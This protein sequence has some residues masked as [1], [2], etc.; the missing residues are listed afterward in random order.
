VAQ[1]GQ[2]PLCQEDEFSS[3]VAEGERRPSGET[4]RGEFNGVWPDVDM[5]CTL[6]ENG[7]NA[8]TTRKLRRPGGDELMVVP[9]QGRDVAPFRPPGTRPAGSAG[10]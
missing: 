9:R 8:V 10:F 2:D 5:F 6:L 4:A 3:Y 7:I 1:F